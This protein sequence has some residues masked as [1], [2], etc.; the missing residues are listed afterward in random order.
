[1]TET[2]NVSV[3]ASALLLTVTVEPGDDQEVGAGIHVHP[4]GQGFWVA[5]MV[6]HL[7]ERP[8]L[9]APIGGEI[10]VVL[11]SLVPEWGVELAAIKIEAN[12][13]AY[14]HD[15][16]NGV[17]REIA[18]SPA[19]V[20]DRHEIDD[21]YSRTFETALSTGLCVI[22]ARF[23]QGGV[24]H[25]F[26]RRLGSDLA[27]TGVVV[28]GDLHGDDMA[29]YLEGGPIDVLKVSVDDL[30]ADDAITGSSQE[31]ILSAMAKLSDLGA[32]AIVVS[33]ADSATF[34]RF[35]QSI[36]RA[37]QP[38][39]E[40]VDHRGSGDSMT[41]AIAVGLRRGFDSTSII[42]LA[43]AAGAANVVR[44]GLGN[45]DADLIDQLKGLVTIE[46]ISE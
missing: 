25:D 37:T 34:A 35:G 15:R 22:T 31:Q 36:Y 7:G 9:S 11:A 3:F 17:R 21:L 24:P 26:Y 41:A 14:V 40:T 27:S 12:S 8:I 18:E 6:R 42:E 5:R 38:S 1:M 46:E 4:G 33:G 39:L 45:A 20:L 30:K 29:A 44:H 19:P 32:K 13:P 16:R 23:A 10:G 28:V 43:C 2:A